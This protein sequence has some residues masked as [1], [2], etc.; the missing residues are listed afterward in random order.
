LV[1]GAVVLTKEPNGRRELVEDKV[2]HL[3]GDVR[4]PSAPPPSRPGRLLGIATALMAV[5][6]VVGVAAILAFLT[7]GWPGRT[8]RYVIA[9]GVSA[10]L[11]FLTCGAIAIVAAARDT[12]ARTDGRRDKDGAD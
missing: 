10:A 2:V 4:P 1:A 12:Y 11:G 6:A 9:I 7:I 8:G 3:P 5:F